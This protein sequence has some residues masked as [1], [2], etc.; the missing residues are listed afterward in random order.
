MHAM[1][2]VENFAI[3]G[4]TISTHDE[5][6]PAIV[7]VKSAAAQAYRDLGLLDDEL[8]E[9]IITACTVL[10]AD[11]LVHRY[12]NGQHRKQCSTESR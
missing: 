7:A 3:S 9:A 6:V 1:R 10:T 2:A 12:G 5:L 4:I 8:A 11:S